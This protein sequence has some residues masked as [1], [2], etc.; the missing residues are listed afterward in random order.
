MPKAPRGKRQEAIDGSVSV[1]GKAANGEGSVYFRSERGIWTATYKL[2]GK[3]KVVEA[4][5]RD[6]VLKRR[7]L[8]ITK[9]QPKTGSAFTSKMTV[10]ELGDW[11]LENVERARVRPSSF[12]STSNRLTRDRLGS[13]ADVP[14]I[15]LRT[16]QVISWQAELLKRLAPSTVSDNLTTLK[17]ILRQAVDLDLISRSP[18]DKVRPPSVPDKEKRTVTADEVGRLI[19]ACSKS[20]YGA[21]VAILF[22]TGL[23]VSEVLGLSWE[24]I[25][26]DES[27]ARVRRAVTAAK[28]QGR[29]LTETKTRGAKGV[30]RLG[31]T[32]V[33]LLR[34]RQAE[35][36]E[37]KAVV[38]TAWKTWVS[39][40]TVVSLVFTAEDGALGSRQKVDQLIRRQA[41][42]N[43]IDATQ[44]GTHVGRRT[45]IS[46]LRNSGVPLDDIAAHVGHANTTTTEGYVQGSGT[47]RQDTASVA[48]E[49]L[50]P[51]LRLAASSPILPANELT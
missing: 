46:E 43:G 48:F 19:G 33:E 8:A 20:R 6:L 23:R 17:Q 26:L 29:S 10:W 2:D 51:K 28:G 45:V 30:H 15:D 47:R 37:E 21:A 31:P 1:W 5:T 49:K 27:T 13:I 40:N 38:G 34:K 42:A 7:D 32:A 12:G 35:Q 36:V 41:V 11:W 39:G 16:E 50:D 24:D 9:H 3:R 14:V 18:A 44:L 4:K 22:T 25:D